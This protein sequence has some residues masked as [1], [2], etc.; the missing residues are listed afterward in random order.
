MLAAAKLA[1]TFE[2]AG[3]S[4]LQRIRSLRSRSQAAKE[5]GWLKFGKQS[6]LRNGWK[7]YV[8]SGPEPA[9]KSGLSVSLAAIRGMSNP[10]GLESLSC[11]STTGKVGFGEVVES[12]IPPPFKLSQPN[13]WMAQSL[14]GEP[15]TLI[16]GTSRCVEALNK[17][18]YW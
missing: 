11:E 13:G 1:Q 17:S 10:L 5:V 9:F 4:G 18:E 7:I 6:V 15:I 3:R 14:T 16:K 8:I 12:T 2:G